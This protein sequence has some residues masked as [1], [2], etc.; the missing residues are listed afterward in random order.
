MTLKHLILPIVLLV[1]LVSG[2]ASASITP[3]LPT[4]VS[5]SGAPV[6]PTDVLYL[7]YWHG[8]VDTGAGNGATV[9][10]QF[11]INAT[12]D[13]MA[14][15][16]CNQLTRD[17]QPIGNALAQ[18]KDFDRMLGAFELDTGTDQ[19]SWRG[20]G[21]ETGAIWQ[22]ALV[23]WVRLNEAETEAGHACASCPTVFNWFLDMATTDSSL[24]RQV[25]VT[26]Y[27][28][29]VAQKIK[30]HPQGDTPQ[31]E[32]DGW[33]TTA[34]LTS[35]DEWLYSRGQYQD[36]DNYFNGS[37]T[38]TVTGNDATVMKAWAAKVYARL[39]P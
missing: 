4:A 37:G 33:L 25:Y 17:V 36:G 1:I 31:V 8:K 13:R 23:Q 10:K 39:M 35:L 6:I 14:L 26:S 7:L 21:K 18:A 38:Q 16:D 27:G 29:V 22:R 24:C 15:G 30:C 32:K 19:L 20:K 34:E 5:P 2:C 3:A 28:Q 11:Q 9:C 12:A